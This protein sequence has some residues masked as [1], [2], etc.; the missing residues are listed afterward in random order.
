MLAARVL[1]EKERVYGNPY[2]AL[3]TSM[4]TATQGL[5]GGA[6]GLISSGCVSALIF[7]WLDVGLQGRAFAG[8]TFGS[9]VLLILC[10]L[11]YALPQSPFAV[12]A[13]SL[14]STWVWVFL[15]SFGI[16]VFMLRS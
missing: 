4:R 9:L 2:P 13:S 7:W 1:K 12:A 5:L 15:V 14:L 10:L 11:V 16:S 3:G 6:F 8:L